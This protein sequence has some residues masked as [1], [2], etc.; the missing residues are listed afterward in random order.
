MP[1]MDYLLRSKYKIKVAPLYVSLHVGFDVCGTSIYRGAVRLV[2]SSVP[3]W[4]T[5]TSLPVPGASTALLVTQDSTSEWI[6]RA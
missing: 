5:Q 2:Y 4:K 6:S 1:H 3:S